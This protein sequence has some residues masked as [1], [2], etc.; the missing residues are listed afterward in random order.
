MEGEK[1]IPELETQEQALQTDI[2]QRYEKI[3]QGQTE[4]ETM[5]QQLLEAEKK[6]HQETTK[7]IDEL[8]ARIAGLEGDL[9]AQQEELRKKEELLKQVS[10]EL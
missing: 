4:V 10:S 5:Q 1:T 2:G 3:K 8:K 7:L 9:K 6:N